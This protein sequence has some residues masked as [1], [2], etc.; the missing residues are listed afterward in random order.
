MLA[1]SFPQ[2]LHPLPWPVCV[3]IGLYTFSF[4]LTFKFTTYYL[5]LSLCIASPF[6][7]F[8]ITVIYSHPRSLIIPREIKHLPKYT[9]HDLFERKTVARTPAEFHFIEKEI[10]RLA[11]FPRSQ[12]QRSTSV[13]CQ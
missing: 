9:L 12:Q 4:S 7:E 6:S 10:S 5:H 1:C 2:Q 13:F 8:D 3:S 11:V